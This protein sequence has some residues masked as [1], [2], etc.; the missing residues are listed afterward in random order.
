MNQLSQF[1]I[2]VLS[3]LKFYLGVNFLPD[4]EHELRFRIVGLC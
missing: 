4:T 3:L 2:G 1:D